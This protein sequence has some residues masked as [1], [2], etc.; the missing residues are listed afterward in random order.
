VSLRRTTPLECWQCR[1]D[2]LIG[3]DADT[4]ALEA[5]VD[6]WTLTRTGELLA[7]VSGKRTYEWDLRDNMHRRDRWSINTPVG[8]VLAEHVCEKPLPREWLE[9]GQS[10]CTPPPGDQDDDTIPF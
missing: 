1:Q 5:R 7:V 3:L 10:P 8:R 9:M 4:C 6:P 2:I